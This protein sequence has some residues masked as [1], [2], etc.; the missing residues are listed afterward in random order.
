[1]P[2]PRLTLVI[3]AYPAMV[4]LAIVACLFAWGFMA[5]GD[6]VSGRE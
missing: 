5:L 2:S 6:F 1:M 4:I 3:V